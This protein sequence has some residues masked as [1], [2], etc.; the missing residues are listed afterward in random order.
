MA[1]VYNSQALYKNGWVV[2]SQYLYQKGVLK[3]G[4]SLWLYGFTIDRVHIR[5][6]FGIVVILENKVLKVVVDL[7]RNVWKIV[8]I[9]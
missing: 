6:C 2:L 5:S 1:Y 4:I 3:V 7:D 8:D 9:F